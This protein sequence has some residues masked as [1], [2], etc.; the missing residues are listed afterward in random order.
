VEEGVELPVGFHAG[1]DLNYDREHH[2]VT[3]SGVVVISQ[4]PTS[5]LR[6]VVLRF[7]FSGAGRH[8]VHA[9]EASA[10]RVTA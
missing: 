1:F 6:P 3:D 9:K 4:P 5:T 2:K 10:I 7:A 8:G